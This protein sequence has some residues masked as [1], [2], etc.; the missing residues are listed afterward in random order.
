M[1]T[2]PPGPST[3]GG[4]EQAGGAVQ[5]YSRADVDRYLAAAAA[6]QQRLQAATAAA[7]DRQ[8]RAEEAAMHSGET[9]ALVHDALL[10]VRRE[11][12]E[13][14]SEV[15]RKVE[16]IVA[17][18]RDDAATILRD[19]RARAHAILGAT[20]P[21]PPSRDGAA[22]PTESVPPT[23]RAGEPTSFESALATLTV[24]EPAEPPASEIDLTIEDAFWQAP[25]AGGHN[26]S[27]H[28]GNGHNGNGH[29]TV[30]GAATNGASNGDA[31]ETDETRA[32]TGFATL[33]RRALPTRPTDP[34]TSPEDDAFFDYLRGALDD[35]EPLGPR[36]DDEA[37]RP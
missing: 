12:A 30:N 27:G 37:A 32:P 20:P 8:R 15:D 19:A 2:T 33:L 34:V 25:A 1:E 35:H 26:G 14:R 3:T 7:R 5:G 10:G 9:A 29:P 13:R 4:P 23:V 31:P 21:P 16:Q 28:N 22:P 18:A 24:A 6:E 17:R 11:L 36:R